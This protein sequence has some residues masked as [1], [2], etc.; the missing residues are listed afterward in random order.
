LCGDLRPDC[1]SALG[2]PNVR[3]VLKRHDIGYANY[4]NDGN[5]RHSQWTVGYI[6]CV[7][8]THKILVEKIALSASFCFRGILS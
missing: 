3:V 8:I 7:C 2:V 6:N 4:T 1:S 5:A